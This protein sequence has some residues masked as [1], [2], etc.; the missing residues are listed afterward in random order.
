MDSKSKYIGKLS[1][2]L[3]FFLLYPVLNFAQNRYSFSTGREVL[4]GS[5]STVVLGSTIYIQ[6]T[7]KPLSQTSILALKPEQVNRFDRIACT[8]WNTNIKTTSDG[9]ALASGLLPLYFALRKDTRPYFKEIG[10]VSF[11]SVM[12][13]LALANT[14]KLTKRNRPLMYNPEVPMEEKLKVDSRMSFFSAHTATVSSMC[15]SFAFAYSTY[16]PDSKAKPYINVGAFVIPAIEG[17]LRVK[18]GKHYPTDVIIGYLCGLGSSYLMHKIH[19][20]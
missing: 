15:F 5:I 18:A 2:L 11:Q 1:L 4:T 14:L 8:Q 17:F 16:L 3:N 13:S 20:K 6:K 9:L 19:L 12:L 7:H 10:N